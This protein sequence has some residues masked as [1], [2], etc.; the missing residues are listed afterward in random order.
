MVKQKN[1]ALI[2]IGNR[3]KNVIE[4]HENFRK[5]SKYLNFQNEK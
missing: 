1:K 5:K 2:Y 4:M 3:P